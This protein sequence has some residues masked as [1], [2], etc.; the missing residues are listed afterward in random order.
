MKESEK[1]IEAK[2]RETVRQR[3]GIALKILSQYHA[4]LPDRLVL[5][6]GGRACFVE[7]KSTGEKPRLLQRKAHSTLRALGFPVTVIDSTD[8]INEFL[9]EIDRA[10]K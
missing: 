1:T 3:G 8:K 7:L 10:E 4:G 6:P 2:L 9:T 5:L